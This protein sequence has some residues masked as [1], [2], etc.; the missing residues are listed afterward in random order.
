MKNAFTTFIGCQTIISC[1]PVYQ[2]RAFFCLISPFC[3]KIRPKRGKTSQTPYCNQ[4]I[5][6][7]APIHWL[8]YTT[9]TTNI[10]IYLYLGLFQDPLAQSSVTPVCLPWTSKNPGHDLKKFKVKKATI[11]GWGAVT[12]NVAA[13]IANILDFQASTRYLNKSKNIS[14]TFVCIST[15]F[16]V[17]RAPE[18]CSNYFFQ[19]FSTFSVEKSILTSFQVHAAPEI[20]SKYT[21]YIPLVTFLQKA[22]QELP[23]IK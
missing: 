11:A 1:P 12:N 6:Y 5:L 22:L 17:L 14:Y 7:T 8:K 20:W 9:I 16:R 4:Q 18:S 21:T 19:P 13:T 10:S 3:F 15:S 2:K 23:D